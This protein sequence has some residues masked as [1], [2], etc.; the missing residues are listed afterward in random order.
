M[1][2][3]GKEEHPLLHFPTHSFSNR[4][5]KGIKEVVDKT[6]GFKIKIREMAAEIISKALL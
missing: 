3:S 4:K 1:S 6:P 2:C 5:K